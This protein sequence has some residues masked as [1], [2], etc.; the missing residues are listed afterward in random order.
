MNQIGFSNIALSVSICVYLWFHFLPLCALWQILL[1]L[2]D[3]DVLPVEPPAGDA[4]GTLPGTALLDDIDL[5]PAAAGCHYFD[6]RALGDKSDRIVICTGIGTKMSRYSRS[7][8]AAWM[9][10]RQVSLP[11]M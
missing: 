2:I 5:V 9:Q 3:V 1:I 4:V 6:F 7:R 11:R 10:Y 8:S